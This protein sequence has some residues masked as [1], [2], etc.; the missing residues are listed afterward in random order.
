MVEEQER[1]SHAREDD[2]ERRGEEEDRHGQEACGREEATTDDATTEKQGPRFTGDAANVYSLGY[3]LC[4]IVSVKDLAKEY[5]SRKN[6]LDAAYA[7][8]QTF[9]RWAQTAAEAGCLDALLG[10]PSEVER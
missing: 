4:S 5:K 10:R 6:P 7:Y 2:E 3:E 1:E 8:G 9:Q